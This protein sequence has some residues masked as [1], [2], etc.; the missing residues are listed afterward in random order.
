MN[1]P[2]TIY[3]QPQFPHYFAFLAPVHDLRKGLLAPLGEIQTNLIQ[4]QTNLI[5][6]NLFK[7]C[8]DFC[9]PGHPFSRTFSMRISLIGRIILFVKF[10]KFAF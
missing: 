8:L 10:V 4:I 7:I 3:L 9:P 1:I 5:C 2:H 6:N